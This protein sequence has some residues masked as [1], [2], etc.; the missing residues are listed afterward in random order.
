MDEQT[1]ERLKEELAH[2]KGISETQARWAAAFKAE[3]DEARRLLADANRRA[4]KIWNRLGDE[5]ATVETL[6]AALATEQAQ[7]EITKR[8]HVNATNWVAELLMSAAPGPS[9]GS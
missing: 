1:I 6:R 9:G 4:H 3:R 7:H 8:G 5:A 2:A